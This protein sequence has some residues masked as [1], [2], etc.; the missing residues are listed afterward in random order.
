MIYVA[1]RQGINIHIP[2]GS[3]LPVLWI[4]IVNTSLGCFLYF[5][6][7]SALPAQTVA[8]CGYLEPLSAVLFSVIILRERMLSLQIIGAALI[9]GG[10]MMNIRHAKRDSSRC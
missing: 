4:G 1:I 2:V 5:S 7:I 10:T 6:S 9:L 3:L 8:I